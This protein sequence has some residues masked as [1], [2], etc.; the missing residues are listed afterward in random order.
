MALEDL[1]GLENTEDSP[2][3]LDGRETVSRWSQ[4]E[5]PFEA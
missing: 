2:A 5:L 3:F 4:P 1:M